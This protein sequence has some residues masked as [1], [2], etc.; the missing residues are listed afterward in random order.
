MNI[1]EQ[2]YKQIIRYDLINKFSYNDLKKIPKIKKIILNFGCKNSE[3]KSLST[4][5]LAL[6]LITKRTKNR[7]LTN[8]KQPNI[9]LKIRKGSPVGCKAILKKENIYTFFLKILTEIIPNL[10]NFEGIKTKKNINI[11]SFSF[12]LKELIAFKELET[13][14][15]LFE[16]LPTLNITIVTNTK[17]R[18]ELLFLISSFKLI[19]IS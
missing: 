10:K 15:Y 16:R 5:L 11:A 17:T 2:Y 12:S 19:L 4:S 8:S 7:T 13:H 14:F 9:I 6:E 1:I 3:I 18:K